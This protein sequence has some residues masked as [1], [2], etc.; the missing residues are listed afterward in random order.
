MEKYPELSPTAALDLLYPNS[1]NPT[2]EENLRPWRASEYRFS[3]KLFERP[4]LRIWDDVSGSQPSGNRMMARAPDMRLDNFE[5]RQESLSNHVDHRIWK[6]TPY[7]SFT[8]SPERIQSLARY[9]MGRDWG[10][11]KLIVIDPTTRVENG[12]P[13]LDLTVEMDRY[14]VKDPHPGKGYY[15]DEYICLWQVTKA[16]IIGEWDWEDLEGKDNWYQD[17]LATFDEFTSKKRDIEDLE[18]AFNKMSIY[19]QLLDSSPDASDE[20]FIYYFESEYDSDD[21]VVYEPLFLDD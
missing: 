16:E 14:D 11:Q 17:I 19:D 13:I 2:D 9:R 8:T 15:A 12:L 6:D 18:C 3:S 7:I 10:D 5:S 21:G 20:E 4:L 1:K